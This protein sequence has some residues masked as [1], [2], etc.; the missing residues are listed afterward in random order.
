[1][2]SETESLSLAIFSIGETYFVGTISSEIC[3]G[4]WRAPAIVLLKMS[5]ILLICYEQWC[6][7]T[8][9][10]NLTVNEQDDHFIQKK[11]VYSYFSKNQ[12]RTMQP[13]GSYVLPTSWILLL[14]LLT[15]YQ[16]HSIET[17]S[18]WCYHC[19]TSYAF[20]LSLWNCTLD[21]SMQDMAAERWVWLY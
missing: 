19:V 5:T 7:M 9:K 14:V 8:L 10:R 4:T 18:T 11:K 1:M 3:N 15:M 21:S 2:L 16:S 12:W 6:H 20:M 17:G 13:F